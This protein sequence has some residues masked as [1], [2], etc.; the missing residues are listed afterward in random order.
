MFNSNFDTDKV[1][2]VK[3][4]SEVNT[5]DMEL[6]YELDDDQEACK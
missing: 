4:A 3:E 5:E 1:F 2:G 6:L